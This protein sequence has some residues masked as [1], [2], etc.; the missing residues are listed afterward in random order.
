MNIEKLVRPNILQLKPYR[1]A[2]QH[3]RDGML[4]DANEN[5]FGSPV[6]VNGVALN[7]Y[8]DPVQ[9]VLRKRL[10]S[11]NN[12]PAE[13]V[14]VGSGSD[15]VI[16]LLFRVFCEPAAD[17][18]IIP[19]PTYGM[20]RVSA[21]INN[22]AA[23]TSLL[24]D[25]LQLDVPD[26]INRV[27]DTT[28]LI[29]C[30]SPNNPTGNIIHKKDILKLCSATR[31]LVVVDEAYIEFA[32]TGSLVHEV[33]SH[34]NLVVM[35]TLSKSWGL[36]GIRLGY[37]IAHPTVIEFLLKVKAPYNVNSVSAK[38][39]LNALDSFD[40]RFNIVA[41]IKNERMRLVNYLNG[42][43]FVLR[44]F[45]SDANFI[46]VQV[47]DAKKLYSSLIARGIIIRDRSSEP[48]LENCVRITVGTP[49]ENDALI[50]A[51]E[52]IKL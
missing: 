31:A 38:L 27:N 21:N 18:V 42:R 15:E 10:A 47:T 32:E 24:T 36:A 13:N 29:F 40:E 28:K 48:K 46:L 8:P 37:C 5:A 1:S 51:I 6:S 9:T 7:R 14:F 11:M 52:G 20:Y 22:V 17:N 12:V 23:Y 26:I 30:C 35:R 19:E 16:D 50:Y 25:E 41:A 43:E 4:L 49:E 3:Y 45:P 39:A 44:V 33:A 2:R 34:P